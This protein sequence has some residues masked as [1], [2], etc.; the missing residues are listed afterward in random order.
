[1][2]KHGKLISII[3]QFQRYNVLNFAFRLVDSPKAQSRSSK[4][5]RRDVDDPSLVV[6]KKTLVK[7]LDEIASEY[8]LHLFFRNI[9]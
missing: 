5:L 8:Y 1:M 4:W 3:Q 6:I 2:M 9:Y 7:K